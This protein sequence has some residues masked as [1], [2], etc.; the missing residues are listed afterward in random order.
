M[1]FLAR[2]NTAFSITSIGILLSFLSLVSEAMVYFFDSVLAKFL[3][4]VCAVIAFAMAIGQIVQHLRHYTEPMFQ[5]YIVRIIFM[6][7]VY[8]ACSF[9]SLLAEDAAIYITTIRDCYEAWIIYN[10]MSLCLAYVGGPGAVEIKMQGVV[11]LPSWP[12]CTCCLPPLP[13]NGQFVRIVKQGALQFVFLKPILAILT[14]ALYATGNYAE[15]DWSVTGSYLWITII[16]NITYTFALYAL[17]L[18][19]M[20]THELLEPFRP[21]LKFVLVKSVIFLTFW[22]GLFISIAVGTGAV[23]SATEGNNI[24]NFL[25]CVEMFP[26]AICIIFAFPWRDFADGNGAGGAGGGGLAPDAV[27]HAMSLRDVVTDTMHQFAPTYQK[28]VLY[29]DGTAKRGVA[30]PVRG[31]AGVQ[32]NSDLLSAVEL[33]GVEGWG[34][35]EDGTGTGIG[36]AGGVGS[37]TGGRIQ[38]GNGGALDFEASPPEVGRSKYLVSE[39]GGSGGGGT[40]SGSG[41]GSH[42]RGQSDADARWASINLSPTQ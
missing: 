23:P 3:A 4:G 41:N 33:A 34:D 17:L 38:G 20:G 27:T 21:L 2:S 7:P 26:A 16:Y 39:E 11:L 25:I 12:A 22:Q 35:A 6:V 18:F 15:G 40:G 24:Q 1:V 13:V 9:A 28:Y 42:R 14:V 31:G 32:D 10:F 30:G 5:R 19:Y 37:D 29:S 36:I 8:A